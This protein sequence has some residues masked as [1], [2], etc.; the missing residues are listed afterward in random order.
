MDEVLVETEAPFWQGADA[1][2]MLSYAAVVYQVPEEALVEGLLR[3]SGDDG[4]GFAAHLDGRRRGEQ[5]ALEQQMAEQFEELAAMVPE[6]QKVEDLPPG[7]LEQAVEAG[8]PLVDAYL[9]QWY[10]AARQAETDRQAAER[11]AGAL[12]GVF[13]EIDPKET[14]FSR[15]FR[16]QL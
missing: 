9:R 16:K 2:D 8:I 5:A 7:V 3:H 4:G 14:A 10:A 11:S 6:I 1:A 13:E 15:A 12:G